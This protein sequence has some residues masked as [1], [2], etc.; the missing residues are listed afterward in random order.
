M[1]F[2]LQVARD[3]SVTTGNGVVGA[4]DHGYVL[5]AGFCQGD[6]EEICDRMIKKMLALRI[7]KDE[8]GK[9]NLSIRDVGGSILCISQFTLY[10]N[11]THGNRPSFTDSLGREY[12][13]PL[14]EYLLKRLVEEGIDT[15]QGEFGEHM[16]VRFCNDGPF[17]VMLDSDVI[18][19]KG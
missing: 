6:N 18:F 4:I 13:E 15:K 7:F 2:L 1:R 19:S 3:A 11:C 8:N 5:F 12:A 10:A 17:T 14:Y 16:D 9:T